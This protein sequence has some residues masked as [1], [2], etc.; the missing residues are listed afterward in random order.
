MSNI[1]PNFII[2]FNE[3]IKKS[4]TFLWI[5]RDSELQREACENLESVLPKIVE[6][7]KKAIE[8]NDEDYANQLLGCECVANSLL[9]EP[10]KAWNHLVAAQMKAND[11][12]KA[13]GDFQCF[14]H[15]SSR[16]EMIERIV[17]PPQCFVSSGM[18][19]HKQECSVCGQDYDECEHA[20]GKP[21]MGEFCS[22]IARDSRIDHFA[23][24]ENP[25]DKCCR[26]SHINDVDGMSRNTMTWKI[27]DNSK[28][29]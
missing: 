8:N 3:L 1:P 9:E 4:E 5:A 16:L 17:F 10:E 22:I 15:H 20:A 29:A 25:A 14:E 26:L 2:E 18:I 28:N 7:K 19:V 21:Y 11:A 24:V 23:I 12:S 27:V 6:E 13:H